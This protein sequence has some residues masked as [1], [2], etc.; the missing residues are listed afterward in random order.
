MFGPSETGIIKNN[1]LNKNYEQAIELYYDKY[2]K[3]HSELVHK[4]EEIIDLLQYLK[5]DG[6]LL[7]IVTGKAERSLY[8]SLEML[9]MN[10]LFDVIVTGDDVKMPKPHPEGINKALKQLKINSSEAIF[11]GDSDADIK[12]GINA[13][14]YTLGVQWL[15]NFQTT[16]FTIQ[17]KQVYKSINKFKQSLMI[18]NSTKPFN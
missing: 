12:A 17:P 16:D 9:E 7:G 15:E 4:N 18:G 2:S 13:N 6:F 8:I 5:K 1:L 11:L 10:D 3:K 14:V